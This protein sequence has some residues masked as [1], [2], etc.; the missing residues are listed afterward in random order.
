[1]I[2]IYCRIGKVVAYG[3]EQIERKVPKQIKDKLGK[4]DAK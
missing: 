2:T 3:G 1:M 4:I